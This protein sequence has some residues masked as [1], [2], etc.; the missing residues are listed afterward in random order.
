MRPA[1]RGRGPDG[2]LRL[3]AAAAELQAAVAGLRGRQAEELHDAD[4]PT[5]AA[6][7]FRYV[8]HCTR[9]ICARYYGQIGTGTRPTCSAS[10][11]PAGGSPSFSFWVLVPL[12]L[13]AFGGRRILRAIIIPCIW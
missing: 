5:A 13:I 8:P 9:H 6:S 1:L 11:G 10:A 3:H 7:M 12:F 2:V 4:I